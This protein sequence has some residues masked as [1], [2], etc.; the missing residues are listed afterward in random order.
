LIYDVRIY[1]FK[2]G[3]VDQYMA[4]VREVG[5]AIREDHGVKLAGWYYSEIGTLNQVIHIW[6]Y[7]DMEDMERKVEQVRK[8]PRWFGEYVPRVQPLLVSQRNQIMNGPDF[9]PRP[10]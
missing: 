5:L 2:P 6:A 10:A 8:D 7:E 3:T 1:E 9:F 4:A